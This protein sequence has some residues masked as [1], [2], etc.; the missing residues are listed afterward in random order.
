M[1]TLFTMIFLYGLDFLFIILLVL[2][3]FNID[4]FTKCVIAMTL[5]ICN[6]I[7]LSKVINNF[8]PIK[9][10]K[11][12]TS[13]SEYDRWRAQG[14]IAISSTLLFD[15]FIP[16]WL[17]SFWFRLYGA[18]LSKNVVIG[19]RII[20]PLLV[21]MSE[22]SGLGVEAMILGHLITNG[23]IT[24]GPVIIG[25]YSMV[26]ARA[27]VLPNTVIGD[28]AIVGANS[29]LTSGKN[30]KDGETWVGNP[31]K[32]LI[33]SSIQNLKKPFKGDK[34]NNLIKFNSF[35]KS[36]IKNF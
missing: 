35:N 17:K 12:S 7:I 29:L 2:L 8:F 1:I 20:D 34:K 11:F 25:K 14:I 6:T 30:I 18:N 22:N 3:P 19:G 16:L 9:F 31:A 5:H 28:N 15:Q 26:G 13:S 4:I 21:T 24:I 27:M 10:G 33:K 23:Q 32:L 36:K